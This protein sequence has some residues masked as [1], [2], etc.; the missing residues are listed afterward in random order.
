METLIN[1]FKRTLL[2]TVG[3][4]KE[5]C[6]LHLKA[7]AKTKWNLV[8]IQTYIS[9]SFLTFVFHTMHHDKNYK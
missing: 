5:L 7:L 6:A 9:K 4:I 3:H 8:L 1:H 2:Q